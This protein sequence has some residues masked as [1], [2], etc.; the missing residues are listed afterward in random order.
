MDI[1]VNQLEEII[2]GYYVEEYELTNNHG[3]KV[4]LTNFGATIKSIYWPKDTGTDAIDILLGYDTTREW[5]DDDSW[6]GSTAGRCCNR[7][8]NSEAKIDGIVYSLNPN[9]PPHQLHGGVRGFNKRNW[10]GIPFCDP[11]KVGVRMYYI[12]NHME[13]GFPGNV[14][15]EAIFTLTNNNELIIEYKAETDQLTICNITCHPYFNLDGNDNIL[16]HRI[17]INSDRIT[18]MDDHMIPNGEYLEVVNTPFDF[19]KEESIQSSISRSHDQITLANGFDHNFELTT[20]D[21]SKLAAQVT[22]ESG[23]ILNIYTNQPGLQFY[24]ANHFVNHIGKNGKKYNSFAGLCL[25]TQGFPN[26]INVENFPSVILKP[27]EKYYSFTRL[28]ML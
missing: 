11:Y 2:D 6:F 21:T 19:R 1:K 13:E 24:T 12:S 20:N 8:K 14:S 5:L 9:I 25:E 18:S 10:R 23:R 16:S 26:A 4:G 3:F 17:M 27:G 28:E 7:I 15:V 22:G